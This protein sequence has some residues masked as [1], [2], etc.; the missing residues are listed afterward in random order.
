MA[1]RSR[2]VSP[3]VMSELSSETRTGI[4]QAEGVKGRTFLRQSRY[5]SSMGLE[6]QGSQGSFQ[7]KG[8]QPGHGGS[9]H[10]A[11]GV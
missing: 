7:E 1:P 4:H 6:A 5:A 3:K 8:A 11:K 9:A 2:K 10:L